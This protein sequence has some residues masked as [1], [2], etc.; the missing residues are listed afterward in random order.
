MYF[1]LS[2]ECL[3]FCQL[4]LSLGPEDG[5]AEEQQFDKQTH[6]CNQ[7]LKSNSMSEPQPQNVVKMC[8]FREFCFCI[9]CLTLS[10]VS[11]R[12][13]QIW[14]ELL[15]YIHWEEN[16]VW[17]QGRLSVQRSQSGDH[18]QQR[19][20][21]GCVCLMQLPEVLCFNHLSIYC[22]WIYLFYKGQEKWTEMFHLI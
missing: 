16:L 17:Q 11:C 19:G 13:G 5:I 2:T 21:G 4:L 1:Y 3:C 12:L 20:T 14:N 9:M 7:S 18:K 8:F 6:V 10:E 15:L 22:L